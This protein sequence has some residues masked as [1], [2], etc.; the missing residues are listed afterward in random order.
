MEFTITPLFAAGGAVINLALW[1]RV[2]AMRSTLGVSI[3]DGDNPDLLQRIR[4]HGNCLEWFSLIIILMIVAEGAGTAPLYL[5][6]A[7][8]LFL[9]GRLAHPIGLKKDNAGHPM[10]YVGNGTNILAALILIF[11]NAVTLF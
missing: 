11:C 6:G 5:N 7:G 8:A 3:G 2:T 1:M 4:Q 9:V 10:R